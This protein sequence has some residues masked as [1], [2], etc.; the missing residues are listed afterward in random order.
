MKGRIVFLLLSVI[1]LAFACG[2]RPHGVDPTAQ[3]RITRT[4]TPDRGAAAIAAGLDVKINDGVLFDFHVTNTTARKIEVS[5]PNGQT[6]ELVVLDTLGKEVWRWSAGRIFT[7]TLQNKVLRASDSLNY[8][9]RWP[10]AIAGRYVAVA[11]L[12]SANFPV[13]QRMEFVVR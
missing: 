7:Q 13:E 9:L 11:T 8:E 2:P 3:S 12:S 4:R 1:V 6:H 10:G 5:F